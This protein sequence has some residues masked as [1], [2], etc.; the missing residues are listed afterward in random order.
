MFNPFVKFELRFIPAFR[1]TKKR[2]LVSQT[3]SRQNDLFRDPDKQYIMLTHYADL[4]LALNH[5]KAVIPD[6]CSA[7]YDL[8]EDDDRGEVIEMLKPGSNYEVYSSAIV[9][10]I[11]VQETMNK[12]FA[13]NIQN[14]ISTKLKWPIGRDQ[15]VRPK[16]E[17][18]FGE[19]FVVLQMQGRYDRVRLSDIETY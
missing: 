2:Y 12:V 5:H 3:F 15:T 7:L 18:T 16:P 14:Y 8:E 1:N 13:K 11:K 10:P 17:L 6:E 4:G 9:D 19:L